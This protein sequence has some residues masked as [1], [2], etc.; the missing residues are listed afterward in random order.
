MART[1]YKLG[2]TKQAAT[3][4]EHGA[5]ITTGHIRYEN[6]KEYTLVKAAVAVADGLL[7]KKDT[8]S[9]TDITVIL[10][11]AAADACLGVNNTGSTIATATPYFWALSKGRGYADPEAGGWVDGATLAPAAN[12]ELATLAAGGLGKIP[13]IA[14]ADSSATVNANLVQ[15]NFPGTSSAAS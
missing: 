6:G 10:G 2:V 12:G 14:I 1:V 11:A 9:G 5:G 4:A 8:T 15:F 7:V 3:L 13:G